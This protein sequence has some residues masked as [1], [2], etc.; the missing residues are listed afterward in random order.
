MLLLDEADTSAGVSAGLAHV[1]LLN[2]EK[3]LNLGV[4]LP[5]L[6]WRNYLVLEVL[7]DVDWDLSDVAVARKVEAA[8]HVDPPGQCSQ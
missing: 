4:M 2:D 3:K 1:L 7:H 8:N 5:A 6:C